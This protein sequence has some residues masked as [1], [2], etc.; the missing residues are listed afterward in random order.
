MSC[1]YKHKCGFTKINILN[2]YII[3]LLLQIEKRAEKIQPPS[4]DLFVNTEDVVTV[5]IL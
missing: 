2:Y 5:A 4:V 3:F 1:V